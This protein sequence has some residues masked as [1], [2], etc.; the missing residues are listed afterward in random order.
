M[1]GKLVRFEIMGGS[2]GSLAKFYGDLLG[3]RMDSDN[4]W[5]YGMVSP[6]DSGVLGAVGPSKGE[7]YTLMYFSVPDVDA[8][9]KLAEEKGGSVVTPRTEVPN[10]VT[11]ATFRDPEG[12]LIGLVETG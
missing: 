2:G 12:N 5:S 10:S 9:L 8:T 4:E 7:P 6:E 1:A 11:F 3:W